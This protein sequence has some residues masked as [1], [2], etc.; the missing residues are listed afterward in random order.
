[1]KPIIFTFILLVMISC[2]ESSVTK[3]TSNVHTTGLALPDGKI[4][5]DIALEFINSYVENCNKMNE[6][7]GVVEWVNSNNLTTNNFRT[8]LKRILDEAYIQEPEIGLNANPIVDAQDY[9]E[10]GF[11]LE[12]FDSKTNFLVVKGK[13]WPEFKV[14]MK[15]TFEDGN[16][17]VDGC[18]MINIP[19]H[20]RVAR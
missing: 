10:N 16:W 19:N 11:E 9:P 4:S 1:M 14:A 18:G 5:V 20:K 2:G 7:I 15:M 12:S 13:D 17:L 3:K 6:S 8:E